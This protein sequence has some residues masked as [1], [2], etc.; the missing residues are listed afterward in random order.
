M[1]VARWG[2]ER[3]TYEI[4]TED[5][6]SAE[7][8]SDEEADE[9]DPDYEYESEEEEEEELRKLAMRSVDDKTVTAE[10][11]K[12]CWRFFGK[13]GQVR[14]ACRYACRYATLS[15]AATHMLR[16]AAHNPHVTLYRRSSRDRRVLPCPVSSNVNVYSMHLD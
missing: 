1:A 3:D 15:L 13:H 11:K 14:Y 10:M 2:F 8:G 6:G 5:E 7:E 4:G 16:L 9:C 12:L